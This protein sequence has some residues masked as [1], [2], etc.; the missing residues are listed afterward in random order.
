MI[1]RLTAL[2][3]AQLEPLVSESQREGFGFV[4]RLC[5]D[6]MRGTN[7]FLENGEALFG[8]FDSGVLIAVG[9][10]NRQDH[11]TGR[12][13][14]FYVMPSHRRRG[15]GRLLLHH[16]LNHAAPYFR[17][18]VLRTNTDSADRFYR[19]CGFIR[20]H[21]STDPTHRLDLTEAEPNHS[22]ERRDCA[23]VSCRTPLARRR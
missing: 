17:S 11:L 8:L 2:D 14:R 19:A 10:I 3:V 6:W 13:R 1:V 9:G 21:G 22:S 4:S 20:I 15:L 12:L 7:R 23:P 16:I 18:V 5:D